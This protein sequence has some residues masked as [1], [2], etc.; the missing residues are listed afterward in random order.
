ML[1]VAQRGNVGEIDAGNCQG[2][3]SIE[4]LKRDRYEFARRREEDGSIEL[5][6]GRIGRSTDGVHAELPGEALVPLASSEHVDASAL[7]ESDLRGQVS[8]AA[9][10]VDA[11][12]PSGWQAGASQRAIADDARAQQG[13]GLSLLQLLRQ[14]I[15][16]TLV[17]NTEVRV[18]SIEVPASEGRVKAEVLTG[19]SAVMTGTVHPAEPGDADALTRR[20][21][22][23]AHAAGIDDPDDLVP[24]GHTRSFGGQIALREMQ[25]GSAD[26]ASG[27]PDAHL[28]GSGVDD[29]AFDTD[30]G[31]LVGIARVVDDPGAHDRDAN[32]SSRDPRPIGP[33][34]SA[35]KYSKL[36]PTGVEVS[37]QCLG[38]MVL[39]QFG[40]RDQ[41]ECI[42]IVHRA[43]D[44]GI[45]FIDTADVYSGG[46]SEEIVGRA[47][48]SCRD[49]VILATKCF[50]PMGADRNHRGGSR[51]W[52]VQ[53]VEGS[54]RRLGTDYIDLYQVH[55]LD[56]ETDLEETLGALTDLVRQGKVRYLGSSSYPA[57]WIVEAQWV[58]VRRRFERFICEQ[59]QYSIF[60]RSAERSLLPA[61]QRHGMAM[62]PWSPLAGGWLT[63]KY[64]RNETAPAG[65]RFDPSSVFMLGS[66]SLE[67]D[68]VSPARFD[69]IDALRVIADDAGLSMTAMALAFVA[70]HPGITSTI[71][72]PR[73]MQ[74]L[75]D[76][77]EAADVCL[78]GDVLDAIDLV[79][80]PGTDLPGIDHFVAYPSLEQAQTRRR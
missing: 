4:G 80:P 71:V 62:I 61:C 54:L 64:R 1:V 24:G 49:E 74:H 73:T 40:N 33:V 16:E 44:A 30:Q 12:S 8:A 42:R 20:E 55:K 48:K 58:A 28:T 7:V 26:T 47:V 45:N 34:G 67:E 11:K 5:L 72:G 76:A 17:G 14:R 57:D 23:G 36:G 69:A 21:T 63:G 52:I 70:S 77:L 25:V 2:S 59:S 10:S 32:V 78:S 79:V 43:L 68:R 50:Y 66:V 51:R 65:S 37:S 13:R 75:D 60:A 9:E 46:E 31:T 6:R 22:A 41:Q 29:V 27:D 53:A 19:R 38:A 56:W 15:G 18:A 3:T 35:V 39:G